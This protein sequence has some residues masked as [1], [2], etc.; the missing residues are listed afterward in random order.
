LALW[1]GRGRPRQSC[2]KLV[3]FE[4]SRC[5]LDGGKS[6]RA[7]AGRAS[8][9]AGAR[10]TGLGGCCGAIATGVGHAP[11]L[12]RRASAPARLRA[13]GACPGAAAPGRP[14]VSPQGS[15]ATAQEQPACESGGAAV[16][17]PAAAV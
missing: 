17:R 1:R 4:S 12:G 3:C 2:V 8:A 6:R 16:F 15:E 10:K 9:C 5:S 7:L 11:L 14:G 13:Q